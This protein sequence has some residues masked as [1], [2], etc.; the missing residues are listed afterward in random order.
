VF[1]SRGYYLT[2][3]SN[4]SS[5]LFFDLGGITVDGTG[6]AYVASLFENIIW[7]SDSQG[8]LLS[9]PSSPGSGNGQSAFPFGVA[10]D[11]VGN[12]YVADFGNH[13]IQKFDFSGNFLGAFGGSGVGN[14]TFGYPACVTV[15][16]SNGQVVV[17]DISNNLI[18]QFSSS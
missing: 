16:Q 1:N 10:V 14:G 18:E 7:K 12:V 2:N 6:H 9:R 8:N 5:G 11:P 17:T 13:R 4:T 3:W 15:N